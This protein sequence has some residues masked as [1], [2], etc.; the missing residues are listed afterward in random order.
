MTD[1]LTT[2]PLVQCQ[3][4]FEVMLWSKADES[5]RRVFRETRD[6]PEEWILICPFCGAEEPSYEV[7]ERSE[8]C[9]SQAKRTT[10]A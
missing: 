8:P 3:A 10:P 4:C 2:D 9:R 5:C 1:T 6:E 7:V